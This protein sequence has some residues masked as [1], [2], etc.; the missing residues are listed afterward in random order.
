ML[1]KL[2]PS[3]FAPDKH[4]Q[5]ILIFAGKA[6]THLSEARM[7]CSTPALPGKIRLDVK[8]LQGYEMQYIECCNAVF[9][10][11]LFML[12]AIMASVNTQH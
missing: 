5:P 8:S 11:C 2:T 3:V 9:I 7:R 10:M 1:V 4:F 6:R 12:N